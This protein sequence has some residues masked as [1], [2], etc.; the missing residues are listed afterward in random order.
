MSETKCVGDN[1]LVVGDGFG[2]FLR[3]H[4]LTLA[5]CTNIQKMSP[6][7]NHQHRLVTNS[8]LS[9]TSMSSVIKNATFV[10]L[11]S[12]LKMMAMLVRMF[13]VDSQWSYIMVTLSN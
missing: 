5:F 7:S 10:C 8:G 11:Y 3:H 6:I 9:L 2:P 12:E 1:F 13:V 4:I